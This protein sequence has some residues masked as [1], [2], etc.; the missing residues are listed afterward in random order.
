MAI[1]ILHPGAM[2]AS[3]GAA[4]VAGGDVR[5]TDAGR[6]PASVTR[7][8]RAGLRAEATLEDLTASC[9][10]LISVCPPAAAVELAAAVV[11][12]G[13]TGTY[14][15]AN[16]I[17]PATARAIGA[18]VETAGGV[19][20]DGGIIGPPATTRG[21]TVLY[22]AGPAA[23]VAALHDAFAGSAVIT[24]TVD[25]APG[26][27]SA[28]KMAFAAWSKGTSALLLAIRALAEHEGVA[29]GLEHAWS[30]LTPDLL[31]RLPRTVAGTAPKAWRFAGEMDEIASTF[32]AAGLPAGFHTAAGDIYRRLADLRDA[33]AVELA[34]VLDRLAPP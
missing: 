25:G 18:Q 12:T 28:V 5:W 11:A 27:A 21:A 17:A 32:A 7:A 23:P 30:T 9:D 10:T 29:E 2:G 31:A 1:G 33:D 24:E 13:F 22:L 16:A 34:D 14:L 4:L 15:D 19:F 3:I 8:R 6:S 20:V 26:A